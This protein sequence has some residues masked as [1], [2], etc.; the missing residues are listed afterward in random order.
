MNQK[1]SARTEPS[2]SLLGAIVRHAEAQPS[3]VALTLGESAISYRQLRDRSV[4]LAA[5]LTSRLRVRPGDRVALLTRNRLEYF[6]IELAVSEVG[7]TFVP[8]SWRYATA[9][10]ISVLTRSGATVVITDSDLAPP[11][12]AARDAGE[13]PDLRVIVGFAGGDVRYDELVDAVPTPVAPRPACPDEP[14]EIIYTSGTTGLPK[15]AVWTIGNVVWNAVQQIA[16]FGIDRDSSTYVCFDLN[17]IG[18]RHQFVWAILLQGGTVHLKPSSGFD[19]QSV[20]EAVDRLGV[21]HLLLVPTMLADVLDHLPTG[22]T[23]MNDLRM[24]MCGGAPVPA[25]LAER[26]A[27][28]LPHVWFAHV[29]GLTEGGGTVTHLPPWAPITKRESAGIP[30]FNAR[31]RVVDPQGTPVP[32]GDVGEIEV[33]AP[34]VCAGYHDDPEATALL[35]RDGW[36]RT[37]DLGS[38]DDEGYLSITGRTKE[39]I[40]SGGMN[41]FPSEVEQVLEQH[42]AVR[43]AAVFGL[44]HP[45]WGESV[46]AAVE[47]R[48]G[49]RVDQDELVAFCRSH[50]AGH[51]KPLHVWFTDQLP[52]TAS[53]KLQKQVLAATYGSREV[54]DV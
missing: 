41:I 22:R 7:A 33:Q 9:E 42:P 26:T 18:G 37:G 28:A 10:A 39:L 2:V 8:M 31:V 50:L 4:A 1:S 47:L 20:A 12:V 54:H 34:T 32:S 13:L 15:G 40:I 19:A 25:A 11:L 35:F 48:D 16:D 29:Y 46:A 51:K 6:E 23:V 14:H 5:S 21:T 44:P 24:L 38:I 43:H 3:R 30:S 17:Y 52:R 36:L 27:D 53:G 45:R 49:S